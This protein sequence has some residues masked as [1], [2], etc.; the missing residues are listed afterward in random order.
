MKN[1]ALTLRVICFGIFEFSPQT[2]E[3]RRHGLKVKLEPQASKILS[4]LLEYEGKICTRQELQQHLWQDNTLVDLERRLYKGINT[5]S[6]TMG[7]SA[8]ATR[9]YE[10]VTGSVV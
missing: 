10:P 9:L 4:L 6:G 8:T 7:D 1:P 2:G 5:L 3:L